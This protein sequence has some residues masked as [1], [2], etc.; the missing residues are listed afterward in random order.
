MPGLGQGYRK[1]GRTYDTDNHTLIKKHLRTPK[2]RQTDPRDFPDNFRIML[3]DEAIQTLLRRSGGIGAHFKQLVLAVLSPH[4]KLNYRRA[5]ALVNL[6]K[7]Y[8][9]DQLEAA[10]T[11]ALEHNIRAPKQLER[12]PKNNTTDEQETIFISDET[13]ELVRDPTYFIKSSR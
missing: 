8:H 7:K 5:L 4:A 3:E 13:R 2:G 9:P 11:M 12:L 10:A 1:A 6:R